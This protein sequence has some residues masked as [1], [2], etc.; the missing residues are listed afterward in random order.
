MRDIAREH[1]LQARAHLAALKDAI[2]EA[3]AA[4]KHGIAHARSTCRAARL[5]VRRDVSE[6]R[7]RL[8]AEL[9]VAVAAERAAARSSCAEARALA[10]GHKE[11]GHRSRLELAAERQFRR[12]MRQIEQSN[13][14]RRKELTRG[15]SRGEAQSESDD[16]VRGNIPPELVALF[17]R[18]K[19][20]IR[21]SDRQT[22]TE[23]FLHYA[24]EH[25]RE[26]LLSIED[27]SETRLRDL[28]KQ[29]SA[30]ARAMKKGP[31]SVRA[32]ESECPF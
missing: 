25:P 17:E 18:V 11:R 7:A 19:G 22:R 8:L 4:H 13:R 16:A 21:A 32:L 2:R 1:K 29:A 27:E 5:N 30:A 15:R 26:V 31:P 20:S 14:A 10:R 3:R 6:L 28:E 12:E 9:K 24:E 23:S